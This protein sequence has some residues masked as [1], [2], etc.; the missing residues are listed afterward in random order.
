MRNVRIEPL[1]AYPVGEE[2][3][4]LIYFTR[5]ELESRVEALLGMMR[6]RGVTHAVV[7]GD[8]EHFANME[9]LTGFDPRFEESLLVIDSA[10]ELTLLLGNECMGYSQLSPLDLNRVLYQDFSLQGQPREQSPELSDI[11]AECGIGPL[12]RVGLIGWKYYRDARHSDI[13][14]YIVDTVRN[15]TGVSNAF[16]FTDALTHLSYGMRL[17]VRS[18]SEIAY[19]EN[20]ANR[21]STAVRNIIHGLTP[22]IGELDASRCARYDASPVSMF[23][24]VN[25]GAD[26]V[27][28]GLRSPGHRELSPGD[29]VTVCYAIRGSLVARSGLAARNPHDLRGPC[30][31]AM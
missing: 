22:G 3:S 27:R 10:G 24:I 31:T 6:G 28:L 1:S 19:Y 29:P 25:F 21:T 12:S 2:Q 17:A 16:N 18:A 5:G 20:A 7:Y 23:P 26:N 14:S 8:R 15:L 11:L 30:Q 13:P 4:E 9:Y